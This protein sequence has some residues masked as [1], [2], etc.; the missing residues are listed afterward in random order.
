MTSLHRPITRL[1]S[2]IDYR[3]HQPFVVRLEAGGQLIRIRPRGSRTWFTV[4]VLHLWQTA[5]E[6]KAR[7]DRADRLRLKAERKALR[8]EQRRA[9]RLHSH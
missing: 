6:V 1:T 8:L 2:V 9:D 7:I 5:A 4:T 3:T